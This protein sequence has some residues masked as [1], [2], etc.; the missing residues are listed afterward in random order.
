MPHLERA[1]AQAED[2]LD[3]AEDLVGE[4]DFV[5]SVH[6]GLDDVDRA[7]AAVPDRTG[8]FKV[9]HRD[10]RRHGGIEHALRDLRTIE[11]DGVGIHVVPD[12][13]DQ[14]EAAS[15]QR[16]GAAVRGRV[17]AIEFQAPLE[18]LAALLEAG[19][20][21]APHQ[22]EPVAID[23][24]LVG[25]IDRRDAVFEILNGGNR[26]FHQ[27]VGDAGPV[28]FAIALEGSMTISRWMPLLRSRIAV[29]WPG[30]PR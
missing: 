4:G 21:V 30:A 20:Q 29:G 22:A 19:R 10:Q 25:R 26:R 24:H 17:F 12:I 11:H 16:Q 28:G 14:H 2:L 5:R 15:G 1:G 13:A 9:V 23:Q 3:P 18:G 8:G 27:D 6:L 7:R